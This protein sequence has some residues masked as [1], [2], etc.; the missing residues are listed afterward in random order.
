MRYIESWLQGV[1]AAAIDN[2]MKDAATAEISRSQVWQWIHQSV[3]TAEGNTI[4]TARVEQI[5]AAVLAE[6]PRAPDDR[7]GDAEEVFRE[8]ALNQTYPTF[9][10]ITAYTRFLVTTPVQKVLAGSERQSSVGVSRK[11]VVLK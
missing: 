10:T 8:V 7:F 4:T 11:E 2:L 6:L 5:L 9:L 1:G 3:V